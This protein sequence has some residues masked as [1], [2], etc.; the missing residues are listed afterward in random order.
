MAANTLN[1]I[2]AAQSYVEKI[3]KDPNITGKAMLPL[4][5]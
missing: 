2:A 1:I 5:E 3:V 4:F